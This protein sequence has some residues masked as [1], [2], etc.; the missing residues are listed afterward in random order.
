MVGHGVHTWLSFLSLSLYL[1]LFLFTMQVTSYA[2][3]NRIDIRRHAQQLR[4][5]SV[6][7][8]RAGWCWS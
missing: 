7:N 2:E 1:A 8:C 6:R 3:L 4:G 5:E